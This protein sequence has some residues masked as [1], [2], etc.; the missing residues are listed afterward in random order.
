MD[1]RK[2]LTATVIAMISLR[3][4]L[5][6][7]EVP[8]W[9]VFP[10]EEWQTLTPEEAGI[11]ELGAWNKWVEDTKKSA[12][13]ASF[14]G[15]DHSDNQWGVVVARGGYLI[16]SFGDADYKYQTA[17]LGKAFT[18][19]CLQLAIDEGRIQSAD[20][21]IKDYWTGE[22]ELNAPHKYLD[23]GFHAFLTFDHLKNHQGAF[24]ITNGW[25]WKRGKNYDTPAPQWAKWT[26]DPDH[27]NYA[28]A[29]PGTVDS[30]YSSGGYWRLAQALTAVWEKDLKQVL[31]EKIMSHIGIPADRWDWTPGQIVHD[32]KEWYPQMPGY[33]LFLDPPYKIDGQV[34]RGGPGW[35]V[36]SATDLARWGLLVA[37]G[38][39]WR[40]K[41]LISRI[42]GHGGGNGSHVGGVGDQAMGSWGIVT[43]TFNSQVPWHLFVE[44]PKPKRP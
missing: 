11:R 24:P 1:I 28:H 21:L 37:T 32:T 36:I 10:E 35:V 5:T 18:I 7:G 38:G 42:Q 29:R 22:G 14:Q 40:G 15:E 13:G 23:A 39:E 25:S 9:V 6:R 31:D 4:A 19:A 41:R 2:H 43:S 34:V 12:Q 30:L 26:G 17:S 16:Q 8:D 20:D 27:D 3:G 33:G 44:P